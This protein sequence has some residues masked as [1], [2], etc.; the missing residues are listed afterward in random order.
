MAEGGW[1]GEVRYTGEIASSP[2]ALKRDRPAAH[3]LLQ[4]RLLQL[5]R[6]WLL[7]RLGQDCVVV[8]PSLIPSPPGDRVKTNPRDAATRAKLHRAD[9]PAPV[10]CRMQRTSRCATWCVPERTHAGCGQ[11]APAP[12]RLSLARRPDCGGVRSWTKGYRRSLTADHDPLPP[13]HLADRAAGLYPRGRGCRSAARAAGAPDRGVPA[14]LVDGTGG[15]SRAGGAEVDL[16][17][18]VDRGG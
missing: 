11:G 7:S 6:P 10:G 18:A 2:K 14:H 16:I 13:A 1:G 8:A 5:S 17:V 3:L 15:R 9:E 4:I 12:A